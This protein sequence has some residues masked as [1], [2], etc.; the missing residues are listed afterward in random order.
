MEHRTILI[1]KF[2]LLGS[3][4]L[5]F[6]AAAFDNRV[7]HP[8]FNTTIVDKFVAQTETDALTTTSK[9][10]QYLFV[11]N[12]SAKLSGLGVKDTGY[13]SINEATMELN[14]REWI[15][16]GGYS[17]DEPEFH[18]GVRHFYD[19][20]GI[21]GGKKWLT[22]VSVALEIAIKRFVTG[23]PQTDAKNWAFHHQEN[24][25]N[26]SIGKVVLKK[27]LEEPDRIRRAEYMAKAW[28]CLGET[29]HLIADMA[30]PPHVRND[31]HPASGNSAV[32][33]MFGDPGPC[34]ALFKTEY[35]TDN[36]KRTAETSLKDA[37][38]AATTAETI[39]DT[40]ARFTNRNFFSSGTLKGEGADN[41]EPLITSRPAYPEPKLEDCD[42][43]EDDF[44]YYRTFMSGTTVKLC[45]DLRFIKRRGYP[46]IDGECVK[47]MAAVW[48]PAV[49]EAG[50]YAMA[51][52]IPSLAVTITD[53]N[54]STG[55]IGG[56]VEHSTDDEY[57]S[58]IMYNGPVTITDGAFEI[59]DTIECVKGAFDGKI[60]KPLGRV[61]AEIS[62]GG[63]TVKSAASEGVEKTFGLV[64]RPANAYVNEP[65]TLQITGNSLPP[66]CGA[67]FNILLEE[68]NGGVASDT[69][70]W[71][72]RF[73]S[74]REYP[75]EVSVFYNNTSTLWKK[76]TFTISVHDTVIIDSTRPD[77][78]SAGTDMLTIDGR[79][80]GDTGNVVINGT[81]ANVMSWSG[82]N[83]NG[84][85]TILVKTPVIDDSIATITI[86]T[87]NLVSAPFTIILMKR[88]TID[89]CTPS[90]WQY[91]GVV[92]II[93]RYFGTAATSEN[94]VIIRAG[95]GSETTY[96]SENIS[97]W[98]DTLITFAL[99]PAT[100]SGK[101]CVVKPRSVSDSFPIIITPHIGLISRITCNVNISGCTVESQDGTISSLLFTFG[102]S[103][104]IGSKSARELSAV[105]DTT[106]TSGT[107]QYT[108][109]R[110][111]T[112]TVNATGE[113]VEK[114]RLSHENTQVSEN[115]STFMNGDTLQI[116]NL[117]LAIT[118]NASG[119]SLRG[120][121]MHTANGDT[122]LGNIEVLR[123]STH[124]VIPAESGDIVRFSRLKSFPS[125][126]EEG[127]SASVSVEMFR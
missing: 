8:T 78:F 98:S 125:N 13:N 85:H 50:K 45:R 120:Y 64:T 38:A 116:G 53:Y 80:F 83:L 35:I 32:D 81:A 9:F 92:S 20:L 93:G 6:D 1:G 48:V 47:S 16:H 2:L 112:L 11:L 107:S 71:I 97:N 62:F 65:C 56:T 15:K 74:V 18:A 39:F 27:A 75:V 44:Y 105:F 124:T 29:L 5:R 76:E 66:K 115:G 54:T 52:F 60:K 7:D 90:E 40:L 109:H 84:K 89:A 99:S 67:L 96:R 22:D 70:I 61:A 24:H 28:R 126:I 51:R 103:G 123:Y 26:F 57:T 34:E 110:E 37:F 117:S 95:S 12:G 88:P 43:H 68:G 111:F 94:R 73:D 101:I 33:F 23:D 127:E 59:L 55:E 41:Y 4:A 86:E 69:T 3:A 91:P 82:T 10:A 114:I 87:R 104:I 36:I 19:P 106:F 100:V 79:H 119:D 17:A 21:D 49:I 113:H 31:S 63:I 77:P 46:Y 108:Q 30:L 102:Y 72:H 14:P 118:T 122:L 42:Y 121:N 58:M 25:Y